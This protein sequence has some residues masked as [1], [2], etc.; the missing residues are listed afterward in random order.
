MINC[1]LFHV[2]VHGVL[3]KAMRFTKGPKCSLF[4]GRMVVIV[5][6]SLLSTSL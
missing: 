2:E 1:E 4:G 6:N 5:I 3:R